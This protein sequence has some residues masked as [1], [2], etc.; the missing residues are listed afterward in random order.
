MSYIWWDIWS[1]MFKRF[2]TGNDLAAI[3]NKPHQMSELIKIKKA[4]LDKIFEEAFVFDSH[5]TCTRTMTL[6]AYFKLIEHEELVS[7]NKN[8]R[9]ARWFSIWAIIFSI[10]AIFASYFLTKWQIN[11]KVDIKNPIEISEN[12]F[13]E[14]KQVINNLEIN[15][16]E[17]LVNQETTKD[18]MLKLE[19]TLYEN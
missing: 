14:I 3:R 6:D 10:I 8:A 2:S 18:L 15:L 5:K 17:I 19:K 12:Q 4:R 16:D 1:I 9:E 11:S 13:K 7:A